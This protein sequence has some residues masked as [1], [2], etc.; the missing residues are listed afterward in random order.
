MTAGLSVFVDIIGTAQDFNDAAGGLDLAVDA[1]VL[2]LDGL[3][4][5]LTVD[6]GL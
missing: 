1:V 2:H 5:Y 4:A 3:V 6:N